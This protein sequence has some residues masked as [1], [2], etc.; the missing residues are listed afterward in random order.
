[1]SIKTTHLVTKE[2][3]K[4]AILHLLDKCNDD[5]LANILEEVIHNGFYNFMIVD[6]QMFEENKD[7]KYP[8]PFIDEIYYLP[9]YN[10]A[11]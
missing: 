2:F 9:E 11:H 10:D 6:E 1:M 4:D 3:A 7:Q 5:Q 8:L